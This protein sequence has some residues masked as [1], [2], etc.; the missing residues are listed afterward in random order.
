MNKGTVAVLIVFMVLIAAVGMMFIVMQQNVAYATLSANTQI[1]VQPVVPSYPAPTPS[2]PDPRYQQQ[3]QGYQNQQYPGY[4]QYGATAV[5]KNQVAAALNR[6]F[7][8]ATIRLLGEEYAFRVPAQGR[9][10]AN[11]RSTYLG[12]IYVEQ[13]FRV[14]GPSYGVTFVE[15]LQ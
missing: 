11:G 2:Y 8:G 6:H 10:Y 4:G 13:Y 3:Y 15:I 12:E 7:P 5:P 14:V 1:P 9:A